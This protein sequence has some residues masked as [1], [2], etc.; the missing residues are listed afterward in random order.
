VTPRIGSPTVVFTFEKDSKLK[1]FINKI[2][3][4]INPYQEYEF[5]KFEDFTFKVIPLLDILYY[6]LNYA[7]KGVEKHVTD[8]KKILHVP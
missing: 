6:K 7:R 4:K 8:F 2:D 1:S 5:V 3:L